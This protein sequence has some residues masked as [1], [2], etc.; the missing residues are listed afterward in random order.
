MALAVFLF[1]ALASYKPEDPGWSYLGTENGAENIVGKSGAWFADVFLFFFGYIAFVFPAILS[2][3]AFEIFKDRNVKSNFDVTLLL[4]RIF[5]FC[6]LVCSAS[7][8]ACLHFYDFGSD[9]PNGSGGVIGLELT[10]LLE[11]IF[12]YV[13]ATLI[14]LSL[15][16]SESQRFSIFLGLH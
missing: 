6:L 10:N 5:G 16:F 15:L 9:Y 2:L 1:L 8:I 3:Q 12:S 4:L 11:P 14:F 7:G 13:G